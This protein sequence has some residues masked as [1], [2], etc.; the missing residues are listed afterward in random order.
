M[1]IS[2]ILNKL[3]GVSSEQEEN[4][5]AEGNTTPEPSVVSLEALQEK[6]TFL[7]IKETELESKEAELAKLASEIEFLRNSLAEKENSLAKKEAE[8]TG[9]ETEITAKETKLASVEELIIKATAPVAPEKKAAS[10]EDAVFTEYKTEKDPAKRAAPFLKNKEI[11]L[12][13]YAKL[14]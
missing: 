14:A 5:Q 8:L 3:K 13:N 12:K 2:D 9:K 10:Q 11:I 1:K 7:K 4:K 6:E